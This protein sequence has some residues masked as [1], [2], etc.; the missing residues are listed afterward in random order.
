MVLVMTKYVLWLYEKEIFL[1]DIKVAKLLYVNL[2][3]LLWKCSWIRSYWE[4]EMARRSRKERIKR[5]E[6]LELVREELRK[7]WRELWETA[8]S[9]RGQDSMSSECTYA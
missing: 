8:Q 9:I 3:C 6:E 4:S 5:D 2:F 7:V 1:I